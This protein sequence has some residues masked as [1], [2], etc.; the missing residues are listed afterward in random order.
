[1]RRI[2]RTGIALVAATALPGAVAAQAPARA[3]T[4]APP[5]AALR[6]LVC[7]RALDPPA[8]AVDVTTVMRPIAGTARMAVQF[9]LLVRAAGAASFTPIVAPGLG[10]WLTPSDPTLG[11][12][13]GDVW[14]VKHPVAD[15]NAPALYRF[16]VVF[17]WT[18]AKGRVLGTSVRNSRVCTQPELRPDLVVSAVSVLADQTD[19]A[20]DDYLVTL[21]NSGATAAGPFTLRL[22]DGSV[23]KDKV[24]D[25]L[26][27]R[28]SKSFQFVGPACDSTAPP[29]V[30]ADPAGQ[31]DVSSRAGATLAVTCPA[32]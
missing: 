10:T 20:L 7:Q 32:A 31:V 15:L 27:P 4:G 29:T 28:S 21:A 8:R 22:T 18:D 23:V 5:R 12:R 13:P 30:T 14:I 1:M 11:Q 6:G 9:T 19:P 3:A 2:R 24:V 16:Q 17:R 25:H 26:A